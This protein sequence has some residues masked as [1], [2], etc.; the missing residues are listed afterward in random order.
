[1][2]LFK[3]YIL[4]ILIS[5][6]WSAMA[7]NNLFQAPDLY[8]ARNVGSNNIVLAWNLPSISPCFSAYEIYYRTNNTNGS[9]SLLT[10]INNPNQTNVTVINPN[11]NNISYFFMIQKGTCNNPISTTKKFSDTLDNRLSYPSVEIK[12]VNVVNNQIILNWI[13]DEYREVRGYLIFSNKTSS[14]QFNTPIDTVFGNSIGTYTDTKVNVADSQYSYKI[15]TLMECDP[16][17]AITPDNLT[18]T[19]AQLSLVATNKCNGTATIRWKKYFFKNAD[20]FNYDIQVRT[21]STIFQTVKSLSDTA[22]FYMVRDI[23]PQDS[24]YIRLKIYLPNGETVFSNEIS[25][26]SDVPIPIENDYVRN[27]TVNS[28]NS[29]SIEYMKDTAAIYK[30]PIVLEAG[31]NYRGLIRATNSS[32]TQNSKHLLFTDNS[33]SPNEDAYYYRI[34]YKDDCDNL[35]YS[36]TIQTLH[37]K[38][39]E[40]STNSAKIEWKGFEIPNIEFM[41]FQLY[42][43]IN[44]TNSDTVLVH[45]YSN[46]DTK[47]ETDDQLF[48]SQ[49]IDLK[50]VCY[51]IVAN[52]YHLS[53]KTPRDL[54]QSRSNIFCKPPR[55]KLLIPNAFVPEGYNKTIKPFLLFASDQGYEFVVFNRWNEVVFKTNDINEAWDGRYKGE[56]APFDSYTFVATFKSRDNTTEYKEKGTFLLVR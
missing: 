23:P 37:L 16:D 30:T 28:D 45:T 7:Q 2:K 8:C 55:P 53:D 10:T 36:D 50:E 47:S 41:N 54:L 31:I 52:Y 9:F 44:D 38:F 43:I 25:F 56:I 26:E 46:R 20:L 40:R 27:I 35:L 6:Q 5:W 14:N 4:L 48:D 13:P 49:N 24:V 33:V 11:I 32:Y 34:Q 15:R 1:M 12:S 19:S 18:H 42:K 3:K 17:G 51:F 22:S 21:P 29:V 39:S